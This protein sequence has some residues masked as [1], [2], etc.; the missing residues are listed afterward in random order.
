MVKFHNVSKSDAL[1]FFI[2]EKSS[3]LQTKHHM[4]WTISKE[5]HK[6]DFKVKCQVDSK[7]YEETGVEI[8][9]LVNSIVHRIKAK[10]R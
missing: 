2:N 10:E 7:T 4:D 6:G 8:H 9:S 1:E 5:G 3:F